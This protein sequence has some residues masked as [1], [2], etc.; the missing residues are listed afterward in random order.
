MENSVV[1]HSFL[2]KSAGTTNSE[3]HGQNYQT[4]NLA[5][6]R[7]TRY[8]RHELTRFFLRAGCY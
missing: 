8:L 1:C 2:K 4:H 3:K 6:F 7:G 5:T